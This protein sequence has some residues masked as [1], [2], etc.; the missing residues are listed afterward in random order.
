MLLT[1][2]YMMSC[3]IHSNVVIMRKDLAAFKQDGILGSFLV[4]DYVSSST[5]LDKA[6]G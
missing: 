5:G 1:Q 4:G 3:F 6:F 2:Q